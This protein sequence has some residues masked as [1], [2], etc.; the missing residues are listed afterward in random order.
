MTESSPIAPLRVVV[1]GG[2]I[3]ALETVLALHELADAQLRVTLIAP[4]PD[5]LLRPLTVATPFS[6]G[7]ANRLPLA[8][9]MAE[10]SGRFIRSA[11]LRIDA[12]AR[13]VMLTTGK[14]VGYDVLVLALGASAVPAFTH[15]LTFGA[16]PEALNG[17]LA[18][19]EQGW[20]R[21][22]AFVVP[23]GCSWPLPMY[24]LALMT[25]EAVWSMNM[26]DVDMHLVTP[27]LE[28]LEIFGTEAS[29][30]VAQLLAAAH[31]TVHP[32]V[33]AQIHPGGRIETHPGSEIAV[34]CVVAL[35]V[36]EGPKLDGVPSSAQGFIPVD[37]VGLVAGLDS[38]YAVGDATDRPIKQGGLACQQADVTAAHI[39]AKAGAA[40]EVPPLE[41]V[42]RGRL[43]TGT[44]DRFL[45][46]EPG[47]AAGAANAEPLWWPP[48]KV[49]GTYLS[50]YLVAKDVVHLLPRG[51]PSAPGID[52][53]VPLT[54]RQKRM[55]EDILGLSPLGPIVRC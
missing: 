27:E 39:A 53:H 55:H 36:L 29:A 52:V 8:Q 5:F 42:L 14:D 47:E 43:L 24:E 44:R 32:G 4:E 12:E 10:H 11:V 28:P 51:G 6:R 40:V 18:D 19:L 7:H 9:V 21:S 30:A 41:Q 33:F 15:A 16:H 45:R 25:A 38:V 50:P 3:A 17:V 35:P 1:V 23:R 2:G 49:S 46:R 48:E 54:R 34:D 26:D 13:T 20:S 37:D 22:V 31:I